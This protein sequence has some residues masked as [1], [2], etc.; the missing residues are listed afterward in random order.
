MR[1]SVRVIVR[2]RVRVRVRA[3]VT[4]GAAREQRVNGELGPGAMDVEAEG[5]PARRWWRAR[6]L[7]DEER[8]HELRPAEGERAERAEEVAV[9]HG[10]LVD[11]EGGG[12][13]LVERRGQ[14]SRRPQLLEAAPLH[15]TGHR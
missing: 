13:E 5:E 9:T 15:G 6:R 10:A 4:V 2:V 8:A 1:V 12:A 3:R 14:P 11:G 7:L